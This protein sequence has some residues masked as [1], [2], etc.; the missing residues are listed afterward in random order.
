MRERLEDLFGHL[1]PAALVLALLL[2][3]VLLVLSARTESARITAG[4]FSAASCPGAPDLRCYGAV[5]TNTGQR[6]TGLECSLLPEGGA[7]AT[8]LNDQTR[9]SSDGAL[10]PESSITVLI[11]LQPSTSTSPALPKLV[12]KPV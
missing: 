8:F 7:P 10:E 1:A 2:V 11:K 9:F 3:P 6:S 5:V 4:R 12:C